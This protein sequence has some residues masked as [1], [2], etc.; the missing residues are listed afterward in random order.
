MTVTSRILHTLRWQNNVLYIL[1]QRV[2]PDDEVELVCRTVE[3]VHDAIIHL[4]VRGAPAI[5]IAAAYGMLL[6]LNELPIGEIRERIQARGV[7]LIAARPT[8]VNLSCSINRLLSVA[9]ISA[10]SELIDNLHKEARLIHE[11]DRA[12]CRKIGEHGK[13]LLR[14]GINVLT[15]CNAGSLA[16]SELGTALAPIYCAKES[17]I[18]VHVYVDETRPLL[19]GAR[20]TTYDLKRAEIPCT[21]ITENMA[22]YLM[23]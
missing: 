18:N 9:K 7:Y 15:H 19:Q 20:L 5:G 6:G 12:A 10:D 21:L 8:A 4:A 11:E 1:D 22:A 23:S 13:S 14:E 2:L 17:G 16:A 3:E